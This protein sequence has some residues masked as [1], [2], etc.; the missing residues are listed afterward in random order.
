[1]L[2]IVALIGHKKI[3]LGDESQPRKVVRLLERMEISA[4]FAKLEKSVQTSQLSRTSLLIPEHVIQA[5]ES[6]DSS[7]YSSVRKQRVFTE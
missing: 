1:M 4:G 2:I 5:V 3:A 7:K 6:G